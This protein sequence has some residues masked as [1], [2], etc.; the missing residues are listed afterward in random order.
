M[1][2]FHHFCVIL[3][4]ILESNVLSLPSIQTQNQRKRHRADHPYGINIA[5]SNDTDDA[6][7]D[8]G[9]NWELQSEN[10][11]NWNFF[12][13]ESPSA[14]A[15]KLE[16]PEGPMPSIP[17]VLPTKA[18][19][20]LLVY[21][22]MAIT[23]SVEAIC[24]Q[25]FECF[26]NMMTGNTVRMLTALVDMQWRYLAWYGSMVIAYV[27]GSSFYRIVD[28]RTK[29][30]EAKI[31]ITDKAVEQSGVD[32]A[33]SVR[34]AGRNFSTLDKVAAISILIF[35]L[36]DLLS[37]FFTSAANGHFSLRQI[38]KVRP[39]RHW[40]LPLMALG[41]GF[42][43][44]A[45][46]EAC[47]AVT[48]AVTGHWAKIGLGM[49]ES[50]LSS[51]PKSREAARTSIIGISSFSVSLFVTTF[52]I[53]WLNAHAPGII[54]RLPPMGFSFGLLYAGIFAWYS[55]RQRHQSQRLEQERCA[56]PSHGDFL[57]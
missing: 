52:T 46:T 30:Q 41:F 35:S 36:S 12:G 48:N 14:S 1:Y 28:M 8:Q 10:S 18:E 57:P 5:P 9:Q 37:K 31:H 7:N 53:R 23:G 40:R 38:F 15:A 2:L 32:N 20:T 55:N 26:P 11:N 43:N 39:D 34:G 54:S 47:G 27:F 33:S 51:S 29:E 6:T 42:V 24:F 56:E 50:M 21:S 25:T 4:S 3:L 13:K 19:K 22:L 16:T 44:A 49:A 45:G 17:D